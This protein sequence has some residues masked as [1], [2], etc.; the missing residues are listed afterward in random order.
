M[1]A[2]PGLILIAAHFGGF[3]LWNDVDRELLGLPVYLDISLTL[4]FLPDEQFVRMAR[5]H[6]IDR[7]LFASDAPWQDPAVTLAA[8]RRLPLTPAEQRAILW[9]NAARL[10]TL[11]VAA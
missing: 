5:Q 11:P 10:F 2:W 1:R 8:L 3:R 7:V 6:G 4:G 9:D